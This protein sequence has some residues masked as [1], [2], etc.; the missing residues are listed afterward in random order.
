MRKSEV[1]ERI[2]NDEPQDLGEFA[3]MISRS[4]HKM[5]PMK[6]GV[7]YEPS[8]EDSV[9]AIAKGTGRKP[10]EI[11]YEA[12]M[13]GAEEGDGK[14][15]IYVPLFNYSDDNLDPVRELHSH[16]STFMGLSDADAHCGAI[17]DGGMPTFMLTH[18]TRDR[19][20]GDKLPLEFIGTCSP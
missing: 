5:F 18:R 13:N 14:G 7:E 11:V 4:F 12:L 10:E 9:A 3:N 17:C 2:I 15:L 19:S 6:H 16:P 20:R 1:R 8:A